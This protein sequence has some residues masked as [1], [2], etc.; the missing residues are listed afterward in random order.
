MRAFLL[1]LLA[2]LAGCRPEAP[3]SGPAAEPS[4]GAAAV[5]S[6]PVVAAAR[7][8]LAT[9]GASERAAVQAD[10]TLDEAD[11]W[12]NLPGDFVERNGVALG[13]LTEPQR[14]AALDVARAALSD[15][16][17]ATFEALR[18]A[19]ATLAAQPR[20]GPGD[21]PRPPGE[22]A[23]NAAPPPGRPPG[24][25]PP[26]GGPGG[27]S[28]GADLYWIAFLGEPSA[29]GPWMLQLGGHHYALNV[30]YRGSTVAPTPNFVGVEP[31]T[32]TLGGEAYAPMAHRAGAA[33][34][35][36]D[37]L[38]A[39]QRAEAQLSGSFNDVL[40]G[41]GADFEFPAHEGL[42]VA[43][44][45]AAQRAAVART[46]GAWVEHVDA[47]V[48]E[49]LLAAYT[50]RAALDQ[51]YLG[52]VGTGDLTSRGDYVRIDGPRVWIEVAAQGGVVLRDQ[53]HY[54]SVW[55]DKALDYGGLFSRPD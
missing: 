6:A 18:A 35:V 26:G 42:A 12:S 10:L 36:L 11:D 17:F 37:A 25:R 21:A 54:H 43:D 50:S 2:A 8:F 7:A 38:S 40:L 48:A 47:P 45:D 44:L 55:R 49:A 16:G 34:A 3:T 41:P 9:L 27:L 20:T 1:V 15:A 13:D 22:R 39:D 14:E 24:G 28:Y 23:D 46:I 29:T 51:T 53:V 4:A 30:A 52:Y 32:F 33:T 5:A 31:L 19:D